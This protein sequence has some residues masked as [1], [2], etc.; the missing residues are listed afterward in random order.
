MILFGAAGGSGI[1]R[2]TEKQ[3][4]IE[5]RACGE[6]LPDWD[7]RYC[8]ETRAYFDLM[9]PPVF[10]L[11]LHLLAFIWYYSYEAL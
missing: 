3:A 2:K 7:T 11:H 8:K 5:T 1:Q 6:K 10:S 9:L 4:V